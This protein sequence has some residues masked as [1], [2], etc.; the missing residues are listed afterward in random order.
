LSVLVRFFVTIK[1]Q[2]IHAAELRQW[3]DRFHAKGL[4]SRAG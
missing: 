3:W 4:R 2:N 1:G